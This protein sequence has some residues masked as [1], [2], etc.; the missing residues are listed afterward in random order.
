MQKQLQEIV[1]AVD[2]S[3]RPTAIFAEWV[4]KR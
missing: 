3:S 2:L 1:M 4:R